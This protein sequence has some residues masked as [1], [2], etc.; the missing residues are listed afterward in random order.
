M[1]EAQHGGAEK[2]QDGAGTE[3]NTGKKRKAAPSRESPK[4]KPK[5]GLRKE[6]RPAATPSEG[7]KKKTKPNVSEDKHKADRSLILKSNLQSSET[8]QPSPVAKTPKRKRTASALETPTAV[9]K[10]TPRL[11]VWPQ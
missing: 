2:R 8:T 1:N 4:K 11:Q 10:K 5:K 9:P 7:R 6:D 3:R